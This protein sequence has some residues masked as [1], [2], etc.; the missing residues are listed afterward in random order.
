MYQRFTVVR[1]QVD[2]FLVVLSGLHVIA[3][4]VPNEPEQIEA[5][6]ARSE[7]PAVLLATSSRLDKAALVRK[8]SGFFESPTRRWLPNGQ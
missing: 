7:L 3:A 5:V 8:L 6:R 4:G 2:G 1:I